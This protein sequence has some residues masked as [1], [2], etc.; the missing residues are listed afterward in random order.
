MGRDVSLPLV[1][2]GTC[3]YTQRCL[4]IYHTHLWI[5]PQSAPLLA[6][7]VPQPLGA[8]PPS[9]VLGSQHP[10]HPGS[11]SD[12]AEIGG[13]RKQ[14]AGTCAPPSLRSRSCVHRHVSTSLPPE[15]ALPSHPKQYSRL[16]GEFHM[17]A[18]QNILTVC[19]PSFDIQGRRTY[20][21]RSVS[22]LN[23]LLS[24][25]MSQPCSSGTG[26]ASVQRERETSSERATQIGSRRCN[27]Q[28]TTQRAQQKHNATQTRHREFAP[29]PPTRDVSDRNVVRSGACLART[30]G[31]TAQM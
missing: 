13:D 14:C 8:G 16:S 23:L 7:G 30:T 17:S 27:R 3:G 31:R 29:P 21:I 4:W 28:E 15:A 11:P 22:P 6:S 25:A 26:L 10:L 24:T 18:A 20:M 2:D 12:R 9:A 5:Y 1:R 19:H